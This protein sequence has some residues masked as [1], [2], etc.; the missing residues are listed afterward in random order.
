MENLYLSLLLLCFIN[1]IAQNDSIKHFV[2][3]PDA[4]LQYKK[5]DFQW[6]TWAF[7]ERLFSPNQPPAPPHLSRLLRKVSDFAHVIYL[8][9]SR[10]HRQRLARQS[11]PCP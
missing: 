4:G 7:A 1:V 2:Y 5:N 3:N 9:R 10:K 8:P 6:T 11:Y